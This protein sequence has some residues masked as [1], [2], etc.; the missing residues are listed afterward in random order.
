MTQRAGLAVRKLTILSGIL[1]TFILAVPAY[2]W[3]VHT[4]SYCAMVSRDL[5]LTIVWT[6]IAMAATVLPVGIGLMLAARRPPRWLAWPFAAAAAA[7]FIVGVGQLAGNS[8]CLRTFGIF[9][10]HLG[11]YALVGALGLTGLMV[12][13]LRRTADQ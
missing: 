13:I 3:S 12:A 9:S 10:Y 11:V 6:G 5:S 4:G 1:A 8:D 7:T 2:A